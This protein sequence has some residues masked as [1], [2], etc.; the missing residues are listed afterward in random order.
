MKLGEE[1]WKWALVVILVAVFILVAHQAYKT[2]NNPEDQFPPP[3]DYTKGDS[4]DQERHNPGPGAGQPIDVPETL[5]SGAAPMTPQAPEPTEPVEHPVVDWNQLNTGAQ[6]TS[7]P[8]APA[9]APAN[10][11]P[12]EVAPTPAPQAPAPAAVVPA[13]TTTP[14][15]AAVVPAP[16]PA[17]PPATPAP[18]TPVPAASATPGAN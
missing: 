9:P 18:A 2:V 16:E 5:A 7:T 14:A 13:P 8:V 10:P 12:A 17:V 1:T 6:A 3:D 15:P 11:A 4:F